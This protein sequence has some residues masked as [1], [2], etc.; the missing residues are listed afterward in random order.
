MN[1]SHYFQRVNKCLRDA[2]HRSGIGDCMR[3]ID[4]GHGDD[5]T[6]FA[7]Y[8]T[9]DQWKN[10]D[11]ASACFGGGDFSFGIYNQVVNLTTEQ[12]VMTR[13]VYSLFWGFQ[14]SFLYLLYLFALFV[15]DQIQLNILKLFLTSFLK[16]FGS[17]NKTKIILYSAH[18][19]S[20]SLNL[21]NLNLSN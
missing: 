1:L 4:C 3:F 18:H 20:S 12:N 14:V 11:E 6:R 17:S 10:N 15:S 16:A 8:P 9:W 5:P 13:Y 7:S 2:C 21:K 19:I